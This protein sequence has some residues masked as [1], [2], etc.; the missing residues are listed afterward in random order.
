LKRDVSAF[1]FSARAATYNEPKS[2]RVVN[3][4]S[5]LRWTSKRVRAARIRAGTNAGKSWDKTDLF[6]LIV[7][8]ARGMPSVEVAGFLARGED[9]V[10]E[11]AKELGVY[12]PR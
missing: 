2:L 1:T 4:M 11:K 5:A 7:V 12:I 3:D 10:Q 8:L 6:F 9:E